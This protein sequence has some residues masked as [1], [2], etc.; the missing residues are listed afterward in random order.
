M[1][2]LSTLWNGSRIKIA[3]RALMDVALSSTSTNGVQNKVLK[4]KFDEIN[5]S[6]SDNDYVQVT[7]DGSKSW[8]VLLNNL[9][10]LI[11]FDKVTSKSCLKLM[12]NDNY[13]ILHTNYVSSTFIR[14][15]QLYIDSEASYNW[16]G[17]D[18]RIKASDSSRWVVGVNQSSTVP[19]SGTILRFCY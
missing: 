2:S 19:S 4:A 7:A 8:S 13:G 14:C 6:L 15:V 3:G 11:D 12:S 5:T 9:H 18:V 16:R 10:G 17:I 1:P